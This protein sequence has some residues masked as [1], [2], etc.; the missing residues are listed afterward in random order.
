MTDE[1]KKLADEISEQMAEFIAISLNG[2]EFKDNKWYTDE[3]RNAWVKAVRPFAEEI[4]DLRVR[5]GKT[6][7]AIVKSNGRALVT[8]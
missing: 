3:H 5:L 4:A 6:C 8:R 7:R 2:G 1:E